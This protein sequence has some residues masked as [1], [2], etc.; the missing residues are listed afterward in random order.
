META[1]KLLTR[2]SKLMVPR[3]K[4]K[5]KSKEMCGGHGERLKSVEM[6]TLKC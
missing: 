4:G 3:N 1:S 5:S 6:V 2:T